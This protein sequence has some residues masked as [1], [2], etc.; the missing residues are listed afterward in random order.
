MPV[1]RSDLICRSVV[2]VPR[3]VDDEVDLCQVGERAL[4]RRCLG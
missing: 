3:Y 1:Q 4:A 2:Q